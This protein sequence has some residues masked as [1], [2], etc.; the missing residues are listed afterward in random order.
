VDQIVI[1]G[2][3]G[4]AKVVIEILQESGR[5]EIVGCTVKNSAAPFV[6]DVPVFGDDSHLPKVY[7]SGVHLA[8]VAIGNNRL[9]K[10]LT[11]EALA[12]GFELVNAVSPRAVLSPRV[13]LCNG[14]AVMAGAVINSCV[15]L[16]TGCIIN[17]GAT[18][19]HDCNIGDWAHVAPG[20]NVAGSVTVGEGAFLGI[21]SRVI[22]NTS[23]GEWT[24]VG[25]GAVVI[26]N[27]PPNVTAIGVPARVSCR[28]ERRSRQR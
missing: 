5:F 28:S 21:G 17:T 26:R 3:S 8:F 15:R 27:L 1:I 9:R 16:G 20:T 23:I 2:G 10:T 12:V 11:H 25:A 7:A 18:V 14:V 19:D 4:H 6:L 24:T 22:P 13:E